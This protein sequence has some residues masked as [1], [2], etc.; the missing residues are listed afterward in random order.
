MAVSRSR[1]RQKQKAVEEAAAPRKPRNPY[2]LIALMVGLVGLVLVIIAAIYFVKRRR[3]RAERV[4]LIRGIRLL[5]KFDDVVCDYFY[6]KKE[7]RLPKATWDKFLGNI[8]PH[9]DLVDAVVTLSKGAVDEFVDAA[10]YKKGMKWGMKGRGDFYG[11]P[12]TGKDPWRARVQVVEGH[13]EIGKRSARV[14]FFRRPILVPDK[15]T[16]WEY[17]K[18]TIILLLDA[19][20]P[21]P[22]SYDLP[23]VSPLPPKKGE[24]EKKPA[25]P[26]A[27]G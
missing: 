6:N 23:A 13:V 21:E 26:K 2:M 20:S 7:G 17:G 12:G 16:S 22:D 25:G 8:G 4:K 5:D 27:G 14:I 11:P 24:E 18:A 19:P 3:E 15:G 10:R 1:V 9:E